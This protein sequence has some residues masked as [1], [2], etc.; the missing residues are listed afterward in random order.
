MG[1]G[2]LSHTQWCSKLTSASVLRAQYSRDHVRD[3]KKAGQLDATISKFIYASFI[4]AWPGDTCLIV[5]C[6]IPAVFKGFR[7]TR[8]TLIT[9]TY[10]YGS[11]SWLL[12]RMDTVQKSCIHSPLRATFSSKVIQFYYVFVFTRHFPHKLEL[13]KLKMK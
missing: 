7:H 10:F 13:I 12:S 2:G 5:W 1:Q 11:V 3:R 4:G 6:L 8:A 9:D